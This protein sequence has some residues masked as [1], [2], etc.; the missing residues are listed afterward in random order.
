MKKKILFQG[1]LALT[2][3][4]AMTVVGCITTYVRPIPK[5]LQKTYSETVAVPDM[6]ME[7]MLLK[8]HLYLI[9]VIPNYH[10][11]SSTSENGKT[12]W[13][14]DNTIYPSDE[15]RLEVSIEN[16]KYRID[17]T[18]ISV[19]SD[20]KGFKEAI[21]IKGDY[22]KA[23]TEGLKNWLISHEPYTFAEI[24]TLLAN[25]YTLYKQ[26]KYDEARKYFYSVAMDDPYNED[27]LSF[28]AGCWIQIAEARPIPSPQVLAVFEIWN[29]EKE[30]S[31]YNKAIAVSSLMPEL[32]FTAEITQ[33]GRKR[34]Q[35]LQQLEAQRVQERQSELRKAQEE[36]L[37]RLQ[38]SLG[39]LSTSIAQYQ[40][41]YVIRPQ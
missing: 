10:L 1:I 7:D 31:Y 2:L 18:P 28:Y 30:I 4:F 21:S 6:S 13:R 17:Y 3:V 5:N 33:L 40:Q 41:T 23:L 29:F 38:E 32:R 12:V 34:L 35:E 19:I 14:F 27:A 39:Q 36:N 26:G 20:S 24:D 22:Y 11:K 9:Q 15:D 8:I 25:G 37:A 16:G